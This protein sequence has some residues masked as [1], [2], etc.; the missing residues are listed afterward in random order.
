[1]YIIS[2]FQ[3]LS[4]DNLLLVYTDI[5][6]FMNVRVCPERQVDKMHAPLDKH[7]KVASFPKHNQNTHNSVKYEVI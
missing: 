6:F 3:E 4:P 1:M 2:I 5:H 7:H